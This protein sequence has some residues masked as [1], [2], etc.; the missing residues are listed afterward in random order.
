MP[1]HGVAEDARARRIAWQGAARDDAV[2]LLGHVAV[3]AVVITP[4]R[5]G[6]IQIEAGAR[7]EI[8]AFF[9]AGH[10]GAAWTG[11][12]RDQHDAEFGR[13]PL[14]PRLD[15]EGLFRA[16]QARQVEQHRHRTL[17]GLRRNI[18]GKTHG[19]ADFR[20]RVAVVALRAAK[21]AML[22]NELQ[23]HSHRGSPVGG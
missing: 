15:H 18:D 8:P 5:R 12:G 2:Q 7:A 14:G 10:A 16:G 9:L 17:F 22:G 19:Q 3:H 20:R 1:A 23:G 11:V 6:G 4:D 13:Q 21:A